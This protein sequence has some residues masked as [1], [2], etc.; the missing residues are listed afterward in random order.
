VN[1]DLTWDG[2]APPHEEP[3]H[4]GRLD[5]R[6][7][8]DFRRF[9]QVGTVRGHVEIDGAA[10]TA[11]GWFGARD[12]SWGIRRS[13][14]GFE[15][16]TGSLPRELAGI[17]FCWLEFAAGEV[18]GHLQ[19][20]EDG[21]GN[22]LYLD[23]FVRETPTGSVQ[24]ITDADIELSFAEGTR[25]YKRAIVTMTTT[26]GCVRRIEAE[27]L[28]TAWAYRGTGYDGGFADGR[29][30]GAFR[31]DELVEH[32]VYDV[33]HTED[34]VLPDGTEIRPLHR[35][36]GVRLT[37]DGVPG[38]GHFPVMAIGPLGRL[39]LADRSPV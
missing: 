14:G 37:V 6:A 33:S 39:G 29:G 9:D 2:T 30:L 12:H 1:F 5:G 27:P 3:H 8:E 20:H 17:L 18:T 32:D 19:L 22:R 13:V 15:P 34:V 26:D 25:A 36:Q 38:Y 23:G 31:G 11:D 35:E 4:F 24:A 7:Y 16:V 10:I 21:P 28:M